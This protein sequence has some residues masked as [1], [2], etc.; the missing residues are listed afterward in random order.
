MSA[1]E[2][3][4]GEFTRVNS[5]FIS[6]GTRCAGWLYRP[7]GAAETPVVIMGHGFAAERTFR[8]PAFAEAFA[9][10]GLSVFLF[11]Y[12]NFGDSDGKP[13]NLVNP[14][15]HVADWKSAIAHVRTLPGIGKIALWGSSFG[16]GH[17][18]VAA[19]KNPEIS[20]I[21]AQVPFV[22][23]LSTVSM[24]GFKN[25]LKGYIAG[26]RDVFRMITFRSPYF[27]AVVAEPDTYAAMNTPESRAGYMALI[28]DGSSWENKCPARI[29]FT[30]SAYRPITYA[31]HVKC[32]A[33]ILMAEQDSLIK[34]KSVEKTASRIKNATL[35]RL[36]YNHFS[37]YREEAFDHVL[38]IETDFL[39]R[40]LL[41]AV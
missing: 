8:L 4:S 35:V 23:S 30:M 14:F 20:A 7:A 31:K 21:V 32:P 28:P 16:G 18:I 36:P 12:R 15:R 37:V 10:K 38:K 19:A 17:V 9:K 29:I 24:I 33:L 3:Q 22:D 41:E 6:K 27:I 11:D 1:M 40:H 34:P 2:K 13:R 25:T 39:T 5:D 26:S